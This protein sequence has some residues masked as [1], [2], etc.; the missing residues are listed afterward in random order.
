ME[1]DNAE[2]AHARAELLKRIQPLFFPQQQSRGAGVN[3]EKLEN[4]LKE[5][6]PEG[7]KIEVD[8][9]DDYVVEVNCKVPM[10]YRRITID[11]EIF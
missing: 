1:R 3:T 7:T 10:S 9:T 4:D 5:Y 8:L 2:I 6:F 11:K